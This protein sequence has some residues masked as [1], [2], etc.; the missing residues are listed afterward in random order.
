MTRAALALVLAVAFALACAACGPSTTCD[1]RNAYDSPLLETQQRTGSTLLSEK[2]ETQTLNFRAT[3]SDLPE[4]WSK[5]GLVQMGA[6]RLDLGLRYETEPIGG[7]G[8]TEMPRLALT[9]VE[10]TAADSSTITTSNYPGPTPLFYSPS[11]FDDCPSGAQ[12]CESTRPVRA[13]RLDGAPFPPVLVT[14]RASATVRVPSC[15]PTSSNH[16]A[17]DIAVEVEPR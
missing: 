17:F 12:D 8:H 15:E 9:F 1:A 13:E 5:D 11:L 14:W 10:P 6:L 2:H 7:D 4:Q 3:L 16:P